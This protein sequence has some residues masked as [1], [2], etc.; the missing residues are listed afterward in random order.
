MQGGF[1]GT[2]LVRPDTGISL[3]LARQSLLEGM[4]ASKER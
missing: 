1:T 2:L 4:G 3:V